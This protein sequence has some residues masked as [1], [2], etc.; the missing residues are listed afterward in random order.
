MGTGTNG[1]DPAFAEEIRASLNKVLLSPGFSSKRRAQLLRY[2]VEE[3]LA[4]RQDQVTE[5]G[6]GLDVL[7]RPE[8]FDPR[9]DSTVRS[10][11]SRLRRS[12]AEYYEGVGAG[13][14]V[15][16]EFPGRGYAPVF[17]TGAGKSS[18]TPAARQDPRM[19]VWGAVAAVALVAVAVTAWRMVPHGGPLRAAIVLPF[20]NLTGD[21]GNEYITDGLTE[22]LTD[23]L[24]RIASLR[25][26]ARTSA[27]Q[28]KGKNT[29]IREVGRRVQA[30]AVI[31]GSLRKVGDG[32]RLTVQVNRASD[33]YH[34]LSRSFDGT[35]REVARLERD[36][37]LPVIAALRPGATPPAGHLPTPEAYDLI[38]KVDALGGRMVQEQT[39]Q[40]VLGYLN[41]AIQDDPQ[42]ADAY[43]LLAEAYVVGATNVTIDSLYA[44]PRVRAAALKALELD[45]S[46]A[47]AYDAI[48]YADA[49][50]QMDWKHGEEELRAASRLMPQN[51]AIH[52]HLGHVLMLQGKFEPALRELRISQDL[53]P[54]LPAAAIGYCYFFARRY[55]DALSEWL[56]IS[57]IN[58][59]LVVMHELIGMAWEMK[60]DYAKA[61][62]EYE[63]FMANYPGEEEPRLVH[64]LAVS[65]KKDEA[66][67]HVEKMAV[68]DYPDPLDLAAIYAALDDREKAF[69]WLEQ[70]VSK[71]QG[72]MLKV[73]PFLDPLRGDPRYTELLKQAGLYP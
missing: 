7:Q 18:A 65:G 38:L 8:S 59:D 67:R 12:L 41:E 9:V 50:L 29:D 19:M 23:Q 51:P 36:M 64:L 34:I 47:R 21:P 49:M 11:M 33:G 16:F 2:L 30:D 61:R 5:Y 3:T 46:S 63:K 14:A 37:A 53:N 17:A 39:Y 40:K 54:L 56:K 35:P 73:H 72:W 60:G 48:G 13:D 43:G 45:P 71:R 25:V 66:R 15:R 57:Q 32:F 22:G 27:F 58:P 1:V 4:G 20:V 10:E 24:A 55:D 70:L 69:H 26:V 44:L 62:S 6:I 28:F 68:P 42:Y 52:D 31:E